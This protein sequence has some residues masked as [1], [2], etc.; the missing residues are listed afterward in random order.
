MITREQLY[1]LDY[2]KKNTYMGS[3]GPLYFRIYR[4]EETSSETKEGEAAQSLL[5]AVCWP[6]PFIYDKTPEEH[7]H[8]KRFEY[9]EEG[10]EEIISWLMKEKILLSE[11]KEKFIK[12]KVDDR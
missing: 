11:S 4:I 8:F 9:S 10:M 12:E 7:K 1:V 2:Y 6:G 3:D 5:E